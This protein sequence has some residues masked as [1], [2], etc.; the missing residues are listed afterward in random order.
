MKLT[1]EQI[2]KIKELAN[3]KS[4]KEI[5]EIMNVSISTV[6]YWVNEKIREDNN[7]RAREWYKNQSKEKK[8]EMSERQKE[9]RR[10]YYKKRYYEDEEYRKKRIEYSKKFNKKARRKK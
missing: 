3:E 6:G 2:D 1:K 7:K 8:K 4:R 9:Y 5:A 10:E